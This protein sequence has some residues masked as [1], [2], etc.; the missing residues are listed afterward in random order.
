MF[1]NLLFK[2]HQSIYDPTKAKKL[3]KYL[4]DE[5]NQSYKKTLNESLPLDDRKAAQTELVREFEQIVGDPSEKQYL[6]E[7]CNDPKGGGRREKVFR[8]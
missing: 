3:F 5:A 4:T 2:K 6:T 8:T 7:W 1:C